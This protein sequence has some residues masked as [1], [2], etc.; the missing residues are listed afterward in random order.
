MI[1][2][3][4]D[5]LINKLQGRVIRI[6]YND[7]NSS[8]PEFLQIANESAMLIRNL[9]FPFVK[10]YKCLN[11][12]SSPIMNEMFQ[13]IDCHYSL[14][15][16]RVLASKRRSSKKYSI[17]TIKGPQIWQIIS[18]EI[19]NSESFSIFNLNINPMQ[20]LSCRCKI[21]CSFITNLR[22]ID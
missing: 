21:L 9:K 19:R 14:K 16:L 5:H 20:R 22:Y 8:F 17:D 11:G 12:L 3:S 4:A 13:I 10:I 18:L 6:A 7:Y 15:N 2:R 1:T